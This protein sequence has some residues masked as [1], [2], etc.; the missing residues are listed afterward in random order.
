M[1]NRHIYLVGAWASVVPVI[2]RDLPPVWRGIKGDPSKY[3]DKHGCANKYQPMETQS[4][5]AL[6]QATGLVRLVIIEYWRTRSASGHCWNVGL[7]R[8]APGW[9]A[10]TVAVRTFWPVPV[11]CISQHAPTLRFYIRHI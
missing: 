6:Q 2:L 1:P 4:S 3:H 11:G 8:A 5:P 7:C 10:L 9:N